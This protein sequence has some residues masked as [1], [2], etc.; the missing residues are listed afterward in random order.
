MMLKRVYFSIDIWNVQTWRFC[1]YTFHYKW[2]VR[3][4]DYDGSSAIAMFIAMKTGISS[5]QPSIATRN[6]NA[7]EYGALS[8][9][10]N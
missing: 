3:L 7:E 10:G 6:R 5:E 1:E 9:D 8:L 2:D 4:G